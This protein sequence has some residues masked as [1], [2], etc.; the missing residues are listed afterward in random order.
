MHVSV[1]GAFRAF[2]EPFDGVVHH[3]YLDAMGFVAI[4]V[5]NVVDPVAEAKTLPFQFKS[6]PARMASESEIESEWQSLKANAALAKKGYKAAAKVT[7]L[8]L[9]DEAIGRLIQK[10]LFTNEKT[11]RRQECFA[12]WDSWPADAQLG[13][14]SMA[15]AMGASSFAEFPKFSE[16]CR[17]MD[18]TAAAAQ[19]RMAE[20]GNPGMAHR[21]AADQLLFRNAALVL[22]KKLDIAVLHYPEKARTPLTPAMAEK[23]NAPVVGKRRAA[24]AAQ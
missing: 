11:I 23:R 24:K 15:W 14:M 21:N 1:Q 9:S 17:V 10:R 8:E 12:R 13:L 16:S 20:G 2:N 22:S 6:D 18:F 4:G 7:D 5:S 3:M 19:C